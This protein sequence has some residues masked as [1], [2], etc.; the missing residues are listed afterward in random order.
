M[1]R[2]IEKNIFPD[3]LNSSFWG[4]FSDP[5]IFLDRI[6]LWA[7]KITRNNF[8]HFKWY[9][10]QNGWFGKFVLISVFWKVDDFKIQI[11]VIFFHQISTTVVSME[12]SCSKFFKNTMIFEKFT[13]SVP[14]MTKKDGKIYFTE[15]SR[16]SWLG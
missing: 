4:N 8:F 7:Q 11:F 6:G 10:T 13:T 1:K 14:P 9:I 5:L 2:F 16:N 15:S 3:F 12:P